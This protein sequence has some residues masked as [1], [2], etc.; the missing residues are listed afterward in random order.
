MISSSAGHTQQKKLKPRWGFPKLEVQLLGSFLSGN[1]TIWGSILGVPC[2]RRPQNR[3]IGPAAQKLALLRENGV[4]PGYE[5]NSLPTSKSWLKILIVLGPQDFTSRVD[6]ASFFLPPTAFLCCKQWYGTHHPHRMRS[7]SAK[8]RS[9]PQA[10]G[11]ESPACAE[12]AS[13]SLPADPHTAT[14]V[15]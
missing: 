14:T 2:F 4:R 12:A 1:P 15:G 5:K 11:S 7:Q 6:L 8:P 3:F 10:Q 9:R 13:P